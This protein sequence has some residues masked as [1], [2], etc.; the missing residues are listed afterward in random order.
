MFMHH[1]KGKSITFV[2]VCDHHLNFAIFDQIVQKR[3]MRL[4]FG[5][6]SRRNFQK[7]G[8][9]AYAGGSG[10]ERQD[11]QCCCRCCQPHL[12]RTCLPNNTISWQY[13]MR[14]PYKVQHS[15]LRGIRCY[16]AARILLQVF[17]MCSRRMQQWCPFG[18][19]MSKTYMA[20][21][22]RHKSFSSLESVQGYGLGSCEPST[23]CWV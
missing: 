1:T 9:P 19:T 22:R 21:C 16:K 13:Y 10:K 18:R 14:Y 12:R 11:V 3:N 8:Y 7:T 23:Q 5:Y 6:I 20:V 15:Q 2:Y 4:N 17:S